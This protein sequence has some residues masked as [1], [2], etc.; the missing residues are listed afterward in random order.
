MPI[1]NE[2]PVTKPKGLRARLLG[3]TEEEVLENLKDLSPNALL[4]KSSEVDFL[5]GVALALEKGASSRTKKEAVKIAAKN[6]HLQIIKLLI[7]KGV[8]NITGVNIHYKKD[9][10]LCA[11]AYHGHLEVVKY[12][13]E[14]GAIVD[15]AHNRPLAFA[16]SC[17][18][19]HL[20]VVKFLVENGASI[21]D[22]EQ[23]HSRWK[24]IRNKEVKDYLVKQ[25]A[26]PSLIQ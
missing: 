10:A 4:L 19:G 11:A 7:E 21:Q 9:D 5:R 12:L 16:A 22:A 2:T 13:V 17:Y 18:T 25:G 24:F 15:A 23:N 8:N 14:N 1:E 26:N 3:P 6:G 20:P